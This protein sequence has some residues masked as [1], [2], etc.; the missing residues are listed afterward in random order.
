[1]TNAGT[2]VVAEGATAAPERFGEA[3]RANR[4]ADPNMKSPRGYGSAQQGRLLGAGR[5]A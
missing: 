2:T 5:A 4:V 1:M 3:L